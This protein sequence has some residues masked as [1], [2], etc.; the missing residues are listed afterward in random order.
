[1]ASLLE[2]GKKSHPCGR[3]QW[4]SGNHGETATAPAPHFTKKK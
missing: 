3:R 1:M 4:C 2:W